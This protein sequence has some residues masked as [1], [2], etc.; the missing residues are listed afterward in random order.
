MGYSRSELMGKEFVLFMRRMVF[1]A[2][3]LL[4]QW[5]GGAAY[6]Q[7]VVHGKVIDRL[8]REPLELAVV[9]NARTLKNTLTDK[10]GQF[11]RPGAGK[12]LQYD[13]ERI[14]VRVYFQAEIRDSAG[15]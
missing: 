13:L 8:T 4:M 6:G 15:G 9:T 12:P 5:F 10:D 14:A 11:G 2:I 7:M 3:V 1:A